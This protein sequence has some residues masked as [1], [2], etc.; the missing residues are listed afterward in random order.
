MALGNQVSPE[1]S[2]SKDSMGE[3]RRLSKG[4]FKVNSK[5]RRHSKKK[6]KDNTTYITVPESVMLGFNPRTQMPWGFDGCGDGNAK[7]IMPPGYEFDHMLEERIED[8]NAI[9][10]PSMAG[11]NVATVVLLGLEVYLMV[12]WSSMFGPMPVVAY[13]M[14][15]LTVLIFIPVIFSVRF[16]L[17]SMQIRSYIERL[18]DKLQGDLE[19]GGKP[20]GAVHFERIEYSRTEI[21]NHPFVG[22]RTGFVQRTALAVELFLDNPEIVAANKQKMQA[23][24]E[25]MARKKAAGDAEE[26]SQ[27]KKKQIDWSQVETP[28]MEINKVMDFL[29]QIHLGRLAATIRRSRMTFDRMEKLT[30]LEWR[31]LGVDRTE[32]KLIRSGLDRRA[33]ELGLNDY[34]NLS[35]TMSDG[36]GRRRSK[37]SSGIFKV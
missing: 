4:A 16:T 2:H 18:D 3:I 32:M 37:G 9:D 36:S 34:R 1:H 30:D 14:Y 13:L 5:D 31:D 20:L 27:K 21:W 25:A 10:K 28:G 24:N 6:S 23:Q 29:Q 26:A 17:K 35:K 15:L 19:K 8:I 11:S 7:F 12:T 22:H 33:D